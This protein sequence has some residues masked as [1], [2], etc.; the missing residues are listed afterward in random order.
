MT[1]EFTGAGD[2]KRSMELLW[3]LPER[4]RRGPKPKLTVDEIVA[5]AVGIADS[6]GLAALS[7]RRV[8]QALGVSPMSL[9]TYVPSKAELVDVMLDRMVGEAR[10]VFPPGATWREKLTLRAMQDWER[11]Q[12]HPWMLQLGKH[13]PPL[14]PNL[15]RR[16]ESLLGILEEVG[17]SELEMDRVAVLLLSY[18]QGS[19]RQAVEA[20]QVQ[21]QTGVSDAQWW[22]SQEPWLALVMNPE[23]FPLATRVGAVVGETFESITD[24]ATN[25]EFG[26]Q[27]VL[28]G[29]EVFVESRKAKTP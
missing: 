12:R 20:Q 7:M 5:A 13:R 23:Q 4:G 26:L 15:L 18:I 9:Y 24:P 27:R 6:E 1:T 19:V 28:D 3:G 8:A 14:G 25:F 16:Y 22:L 29:I 11:G 17:L 10:D 21:Q 2:P